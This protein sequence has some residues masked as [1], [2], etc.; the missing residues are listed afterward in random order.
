MIKRFCLF[1][2]KRLI[3]TLFDLVSPPRLRVDRGACEHT[4][5]GSTLSRGIPS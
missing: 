4:Q 1:Q 2:V 5:F 3:V